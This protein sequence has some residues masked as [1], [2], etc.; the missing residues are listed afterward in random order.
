M[1]DEHDIDEGQQ[2]ATDL[3]AEMQKLDNMDIASMLLDLKKE[4]IKELLAKARIGILTHQEHAVIARL[5][6]DNGLVLPE[7]YIGGNPKKNKT[8]PSSQKQDGAEEEVL[9][10]F[11]PDEEFE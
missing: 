6:A 5:L 9:P 1:S 10:V 11:D 4:Q 7:G 2:P 8:D 3:T